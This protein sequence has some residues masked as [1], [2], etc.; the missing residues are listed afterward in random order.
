MTEKELVTRLNQL[1]EQIF[2]LDLW[3]TDSFELRKER[4]AVCEQLVKLHPKKY[5]KELEEA[6]EDFYRD[7]DW[8]EYNKQY[9]HLNKYYIYKTNK[10]WYNIIEP[11]WFLLAKVELSHLYF[12]FFFTNKALFVYFSTF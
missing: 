11:C 3:K 5:A 7:P 4:I 10:L 12:S 6:N 9:I 8:D 2:S 1:K